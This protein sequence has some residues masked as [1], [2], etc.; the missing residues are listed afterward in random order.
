M[1]T[2]SLVALGLCLIALWYI[3]GQTSTYPI[4]NYP[5]RNGPVVAFGDSLI[6]GYGSTDEHDA[7]SLLEQKIGEPIINKGMSGDTTGDGLRRVNDV[8]KLKPRIVLLL[9]GG[10]DALRKLPQEETFGNLEKII[11][12]LQKDGSVVVL[13]GVRGGL[14]SD[15]FDDSFE[16]LAQKTGSAYVPDVLDDIFS[17]PDLMFDQIHPND[18]GYALIANKIEPVLR[19]LLR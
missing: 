19:P 18:K 12:T 13:L 7:I 9:L 15:T 2:L 14:F 6:E 17:Y 11:T 1:R 3:L 8:M 4:T 5:P 16:L 10:N